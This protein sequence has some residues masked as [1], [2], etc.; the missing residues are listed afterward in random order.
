MENNFK[1][2]F[3]MPL[4]SQLMKQRGPLINSSIKN[5]KIHEV[6]DNETFEK[7]KERIKKSILFEPITFG[8]IKLVDYKYEERTLRPTE[9]YWVHSKDNYIYELSVPF[10]GD[11]VLL[12]HRPD[13][14]SFQSSDHG[15]IAPYGSEIKVYVEL[16]ELNPDESKLK[17]DELLRLTKDVANKNNDD[18]MMWNKVAEQ[19]IDEDLDSHRSELI[20]IFGK[21]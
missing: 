4:L 7:T 14:L 19:K 10:T 9:Q 11:K 15:I 13:S 8:N 3:E 17:A 12:E 20:R 6:E 5:L 2:P 18:V 16:S 21:K 1:T